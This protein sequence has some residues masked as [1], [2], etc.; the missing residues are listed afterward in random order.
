MYIHIYIYTH[1][2][3]YKYKY[4]QCYQQSLVKEHQPHDALWHTYMYKHIY[5]S[6]RRE[7]MHRNTNINIHTYTYVWWY[8][9]IYT[10]VHRYTFAH[11]YVRMMSP[12]A[13]WHRASPQHIHNAS[14]QKICTYVHMY[15]Y[16]QQ[17]YV[18]ISVYIH[19]H[20]NTYV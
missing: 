16:I 2:R 1:I 19:T 14:R 12:P 4:K 5:I 18:H 7:F 10:F 6:I 20:I 11:I 9:Y 13:S 8:I 17:V 15:I 3:I